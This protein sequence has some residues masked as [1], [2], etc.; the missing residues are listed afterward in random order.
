MGEFR[1]EIEIADARGERFEAVRALVDTGASY[2]WLPRSLL[3]ALGHEPED[4]WD[5]VLAD[6]RKVS[7]GYKWIVVRVEGRA[8]PTPVVFGEDGTEAL[9]GVVTLE[10]SRLGVDPVNRRLI[11]IPALL[12]GFR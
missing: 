11:P 8:H 1:V 5:F 7:Y 3:L 4:E 12:T 9:L 10:E 6:G 2:T